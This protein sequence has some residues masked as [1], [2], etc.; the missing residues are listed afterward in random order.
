MAHWTKDHEAML[1]TLWAEGYSGTE[2]ADELNE[3]VGPIPN[4][5]GRRGPRKINRDMVIA[6][7]RRMALPRRGSPLGQRPVDFI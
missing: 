7:A 6:K 3:K 5:Y 4:P 2:I 1:E